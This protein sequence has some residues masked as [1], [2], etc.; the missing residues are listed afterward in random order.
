MSYPDKK[1]MEGI[2]FQYNILAA[3][4]GGILGKPDD[5]DHIHSAQL[6]MVDLDSSAAAPV[7]TLTNVISTAED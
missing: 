2:K 1:Y 4:G 7:S 6:Q 3:L 5:A